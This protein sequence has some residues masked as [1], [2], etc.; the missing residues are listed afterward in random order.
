ML[1]LKI[2]GSEAVRLFSLAAAQGLETAKQALRGLAA[3][4]VPEAIAAARRLGLAP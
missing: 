3:E 4:G 1:G 2:N